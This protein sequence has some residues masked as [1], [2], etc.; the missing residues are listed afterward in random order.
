MAF[1][2]HHQ[3]CEIYCGPA[4]VMMMLRHAGVSLNGLYQSN[5]MSRVAVCH[6]ELSAYGVEIVS[7]GDIASPPMALACAASKELALSPRPNLRYE[8]Y[9]PQ[10]GPPPPPLTD[11]EALLQIRSSLNAAL[12]HRRSE[13]RARAEAAR[14]APQ[15]TT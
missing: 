6:S 13:R 1:P 10:S 5:L 11:V 12:A 7:F 4:C 15:G 14:R 9:P 3:D 2:S 8:I